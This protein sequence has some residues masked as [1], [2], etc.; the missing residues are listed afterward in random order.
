MRHAIFE[1]HRR[2]CGKS[3]VLA[4]SFFKGLEQ[5]IQQTRRNIEAYALNSA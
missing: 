4:K 5:K 1:N 3:E 2:N